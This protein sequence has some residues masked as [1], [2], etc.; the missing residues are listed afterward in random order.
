[1]SGTLEEF[2]TDFTSEER[3]R[4]A[5]RTAEL[6]EAELTLRDLSGRS[7]APDPAAVNTRQ[8]RRRPGRCVFCKGSWLL[9]GSVAG[10]VLIR[11][12]RR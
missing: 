8:L 6:V 1:M 5:A 2:S 10:W 4:V 9:A 3:A 7:A 11:G 12:R